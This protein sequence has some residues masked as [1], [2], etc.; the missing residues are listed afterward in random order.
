VGWWPIVANDWLKA[1]S[2][3][4]IAPKAAVLSF[5]TSSQKSKKKFQ[6]K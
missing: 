3:N 1:T 4:R 6:K 2:K 5:M